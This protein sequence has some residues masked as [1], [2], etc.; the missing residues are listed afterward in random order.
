MEVTDDD[1]IG[2]S[3]KQQHR[4]FA[5][6]ARERQHQYWL[7]CALSL[8]IGTAMGMFGAIWTAG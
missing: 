1:L 4:V 2:L 3:T 7:V 5:R 6:A 8:A